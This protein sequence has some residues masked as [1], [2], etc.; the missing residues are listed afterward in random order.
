MLCHACR[1]YDSCIVGYLKTKTHISWIIAAICWGFLVGVAIA[2][3]IMGCRIDRTTLLAAGVALA[4]VVMISRL[5]LMVPLAIMAGVMLGTAR[6]DVNLTDLAKYDRLIGDDVLVAGRIIDDPTAGKGKVNASLVDIVITTT[7]GEQLSLKGRL[8]ASIKT[9]ENDLRRNDQIEIAGTLD[10]GFGAYAVTVSQAKLTKLARMNGADPMGIVR[11]NFGQHLTKVMNST[12]T[13]LGMGLLAGQKTSL[14]NDLQNAFVAT[15]LTHILVASGY[16]LTVLIRFARRLLARHSRLLALILSTT[17]VTLFASITGASASMNRAMVVA[18]LSLL[19]WFVGRKMHPVVMLSSIAAATIAADPSQLWGDVGWYLSFGSF[20]GVIILAPLVNDWLSRR[21]G[22]TAM[23]DELINLTTVAKLARRLGNIPGSLVQIL[24]ETASAQLV[25]WPII[26][27]FMGNLSLI[28]LLTNILVLPLLPLT[29]ACTFIAGL[30]VYALPLA[31]ASWLAWPA[32]LL[33]DF[34]IAVAEWGAALPGAQ[35]EFQP[36]VMMVVIYYSFV[37][38]FAM[39]LR[40][41]TGHNFYGDN[42]I[43]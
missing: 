3:A 2:R 12:E 33:L 4:V 31:V 22:R 35:L 11:D 23:T 25:T 20:A 36:T 43:E 39:L 41:R 30:A 15:S 18:I 26:A 32:K 29:M 24:V 37:L 6:A 40:W 34:I 16:N 17:M 7:K 19:L 42:V 5:Y 38:L 1:W 21:F 10:S 13:G 8:W 14:N 9:K 27:L 28:G